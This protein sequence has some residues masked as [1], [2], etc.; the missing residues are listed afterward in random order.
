MSG[1]SD[2]G[3]A[4]CHTQILTPV[5]IPDDPCLSMSM[6]PLPEQSGEYFSGNCQRHLIRDCVHN[7]HGVQIDTCTAN[8]STK[9]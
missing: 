8:Q 3:S 2:L 5:Q 7:A 4:G 1:L 9:Q 6:Q